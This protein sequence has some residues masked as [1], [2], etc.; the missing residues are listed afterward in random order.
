[1]GNSYSCI[2]QS[3]G[4]SASTP[5][6][7]ESSVQQQIERSKVHWS[8]LAD[9]S[10]SCEGDGEEG[11]GDCDAEESNKQEFMQLQRHPTWGGFFRT[12]GYENDTKLV[13]GEKFAEGGQA[14]LFHAK[15]TWS[16]P[17]DNERDERM[18]IEHV[19]KVFKKGTFLRDLKSQLPHGLL[20]FHVEEMENYRSPTPKVTP[21]FFCEV[22]RG[23]L[24]ENG[25][26]AF[27]MQ[28]EHFDLRS[29][30]EHKM[31]SRSDRDSGP[32]S[33]EDG[34]IIMYHIALG[35]EWLHNRDIIHRDLKASNVLVEE[36]KSTLPKWL[37]FVADYEC[38]VGV[39]GTGFFRAPEI[40]QALK[41][42]MISEKPEV[43][44][45][46]T[47][48]YAYRMTCYE[49]LTG[50]LPF[51]DHPLHDETSLLK[52]RVINYDLRPEIPEYIKGWARN[53]LN[54]CW[55]RDPIARPS[56]REVL[57]ILSTNSA[58]IRK[59]EKFL[60]GEYGENYRD[61]FKHQL[62]I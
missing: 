1:M 52:D 15:V 39:V 41:E 29:L 59:R 58:R 62:Q 19:V 7:N 56:V 17:K 50:K 40:L 6:N 16:N 14:E 31:E 46:A 43:F 21:R 8:T 20:Q 53:L 44:S 9:Q 28:K 25:Q 22:Y 54:R 61:K 30:I 26:F 12:F 13:V 5:S 23:I 42:R 34:E 10:S 35:V 55:Q 36:Q 45:R 33:K 47:D 51:E 32:F 60:K 2:R 37:C 18:G 24:L 38:S 49:V 27:L 57:D 4:A 3:G 11:K 48:V